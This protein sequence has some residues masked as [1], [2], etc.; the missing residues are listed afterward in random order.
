MSERFPFDPSDHDPSP[1]MLLDSYAVGAMQRIH[2]ECVASA[3]VDPNDSISEKQSHYAWIRPQMNSVQLATADAAEIFSIERAAH[4]KPFTKTV[5]KLYR[6][7][8][9][10]IL[11]HD[12]EAIEN[13]ED[14]EK[15]EEGSYTYLL[16]TAPG[17]MQPQLI[18]EDLEW[19]FSKMLAKKGENLT[20]VT[21]TLQYLQGKRM[22]HYLSNEECRDISLLLAQ[23][24]PDYESFN[25]ERED[26]IEAEQGYR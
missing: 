2:L 9:P 6:D 4:E 10:H 23:C 21:K 13:L 24:E 11:D 3:G 25:E 19:V 26:F 7:G 5:L 22:V 12:A 18:N 15:D 8:M 14:Y 17:E 16:L 1:R 20:V